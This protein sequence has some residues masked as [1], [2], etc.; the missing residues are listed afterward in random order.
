M[1]S[2]SSAHKFHASGAHD[3]DG[4]VAIWLVRDS[5][6]I[7][8]VGEKLGGKEKGDEKGE[9][10][11]MRWEKMKTVTVAEGAVGGDETRMSCPASWPP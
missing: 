10:G 1:I 7:N 9:E 2:A 4:V 11:E 5:A 6:K 3:S 8:G